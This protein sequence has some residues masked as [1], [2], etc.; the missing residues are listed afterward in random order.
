MQP[1]ETTVDQPAVGRPV[2]LKDGARRF[3]RPEHEFRRAHLSGEL[4]TLEFNGVLI[5]PPAE[6]ER[7]RGTF[8]EG[9]L[10]RDLRKAAE[11]LGWSYFRVY[12]AARRGD[13][14]TKRWCG[15]RR[16]TDAETQRRREI[17]AASSR[18]PPVEGGARIFGPASLG[19]TVAPRPPGR[20]R[21]LPSM[22]A[23]QIDTCSK[24]S[25][26]RREVARSDRGDVRGG[27]TR[28]ADNG[29]RGRIQTVHRG[30]IPEGR[31]G[32]VAC[33]PL[34][35]GGARAWRHSWHWTSTR[36]RVRALPVWDDPQ[37]L[38]PR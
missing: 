34:A 24:R 21:R 4:K 19:L 10:S 6:I 11:E 30:P 5:I 13:I 22:T 17:I 20:N 14:R 38:P 1:T 28:T 7:L 9:G 2:R 23:E 12:A 31:V 32:D 8:G 16:V 36:P 29:Q 33:L 26:E 37:N 35:Q 18:T 15:R 25:G 27:R 3:K